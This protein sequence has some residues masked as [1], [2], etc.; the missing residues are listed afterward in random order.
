MTNA[1]AY[2]RSSKDRSDVSI[3]AQR[4][5]LTDLA[6][7]RSLT[8][9]D[10]FV[11]A[12]ESGKDEDR[13]GFQR[14]LGELK[15][16]ARTWS[17][18]LVL[19]TSRIARRR[20]LALIVENECAKRSVAIVYK[21]VPDTDEVTAML[22]KSILQAMDEWHSLNSK[23]KGLAGMAENV[24]QGWRAG[25]RAPRGYQ[26]E[27]HSTG[28]IR[29]GQAVTKTKLAPNDDAPVMTD[30]LALRAANVPRDQA[31][32]RA[33]ATWSL[34][35]LHSTDWQAL[36]YA[37]HTVWNMHT[38][39]V[40]GGTGDKRRPRSEWMI[41]RDTH[42]ALITT[43]QAEAILLQCE[44]AQAGRRRR[45]SPMLLT[46]LVESADGRRWHGDGCGSYRLGKGKKISAK[47]LDSA[48]INRIEKDLSADD[49]IAS[50]IEARLTKKL[51]ALDRKITRLLDLAVDMD[52]TSAVLR[53][54]QQLE[55]DRSK[56]LADIEQ[57]Q[58]QARQA[59][60]LTVTTPEAVRA[61]LRHLIDDI[62]MQISF[63]DVT[64]ARTAIGEIVERVELDDQATTVTINYSLATGDNVASRRGFE[65][66]Y[67]P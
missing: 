3:A 29:E 26:L 38:E 18:L 8:I 34:S 17:T 57:A 39:R 37:G 6:S 45:A 46:G 63:G 22:L 41:Q 31:A 55:K 47:R 35:S 59:A 30:Y 52:D 54:V 65:P 19:D 15:S 23:A 11:D 66:L 13:P 43:D 53:T 24:R 48:V 67:P 58:A 42:P 5:A 36:T 10:E 4:R 12:V 50:E 51:A 44:T 16:P 9:V 40:K 27:A 56:C 61:L 2:L 21:N 14:L 7:S 25:G 64:E 1:V 32:K 28:A 49:A 62:R 60:V 33:G 20:Y